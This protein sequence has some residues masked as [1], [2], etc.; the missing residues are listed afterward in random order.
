MKVLFYL[1]PPSLTAECSA[2]SLF[3]KTVLLSS[4]R[5]RDKCE[6][7]SFKVPLLVDITVSWN[8][9]FKTFFPSGFMNVRTRHQVIS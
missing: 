8:K 1:R 4:H 3:P 2:R 9:P 7:L 5:V 6:L